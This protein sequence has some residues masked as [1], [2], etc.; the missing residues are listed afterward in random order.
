MNILKGDRVSKSCPRSLWESLYE[1]RSLEDRLVQAAEQTRPDFSA[2]VYDKRIRRI[3]EARERNN[4]PNA[5]DYLQRL[6]DLDLKE[7]KDSAQRAALVF[8]FKE[9]LKKLPALRKDMQAKGWCCTKL[10][11]K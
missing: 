1:S 9:E 3:I 6:N 10:C 4:Y 2:R 7:G 5:L 8:W 11:A